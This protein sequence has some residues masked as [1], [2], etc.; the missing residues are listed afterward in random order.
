MNRLLSCLFYVEAYIYVVDE[1]LELAYAITP[2]LCC[3]CI[4][5]INYHHY[6]IYSTVI[7]DRWRRKNT[8]VGPCV[9][10]TTYI[11]SSVRR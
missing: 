9:F 11:R 6:V 1:E 4:Y 10:E 3:C 7:I 2:C 8:F 5:C